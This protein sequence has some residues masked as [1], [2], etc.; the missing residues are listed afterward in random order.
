[1]TNYALL[2]SHDLECGKEDLFRLEKLLSEYII[3]YVIGG[4]PLDMINSYIHKNNLTKNDL[5]LIYCACHGVK[6]G[7]KIGS[8]V[9]LLT[10]LVNSDGSITHSKEIDDILSKLPCK[11]I[12]IVDCCHSETFGDFY[13]GNSLTFIGTSRLNELSASYSIDSKPYCGSLICLLEYLVKS[14]K[15][16]SANTIKSTY[17]SFYKKYNIKQ[18]L[19]FKNYN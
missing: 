7:I 17:K 2:L 4:N 9:R 13:T 14:G 11:I 18:E 1:M 12:L 10:C 6:R 8:N 3:Y 16:I 15:G 19:I 5:L